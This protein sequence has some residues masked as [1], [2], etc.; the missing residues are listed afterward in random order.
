M[1]GVI[2]TYILRRSRRQKL[3][4]NENTPP[5]YETIDPLYE[6]VTQPHESNRPQAALQLDVTLS[7]NDAY[8][9]AR[10]DTSSDNK[11]HI[12]LKNNDAYE[13]CDTN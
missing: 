9:Y 2:V 8:N 7:N 6:T 5:L 12:F 11:V 3:D 1:V 4:H 13:Y 10:H